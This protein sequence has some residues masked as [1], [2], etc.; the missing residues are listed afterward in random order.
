MVLLF[1]LKG[2]IRIFLYY[3]DPGKIHPDPQPC[4]ELNIIKHITIY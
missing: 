4:L 1:F 3:P 2:R